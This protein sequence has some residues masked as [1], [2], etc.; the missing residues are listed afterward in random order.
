MTAVQ[1]MTT[2]VLVLT[3]TKG[4]GSR[5]P[6]MNERAIARYQGRYTTA[7]AKALVRREVRI[8]RR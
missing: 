1:D 6:T 3:I 8:I 5:Q 2:R 4:D 7:I